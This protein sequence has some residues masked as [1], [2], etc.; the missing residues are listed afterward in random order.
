MEA[1]KQSAPQMKAV[2]GQDVAIGDVL[3]QQK[4]GRKF[5]SDIPKTCRCVHY[6]KYNCYSSRKEY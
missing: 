5:S 2:F 3:A 1:L 4:G 6:Y